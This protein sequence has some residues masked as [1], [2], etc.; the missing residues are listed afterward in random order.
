VQ[1]VH[2]RDYGDFAIGEILWG[3][4][5]IAWGLIELVIITVRKLR[6]D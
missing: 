3:L 1:E 5:E 6:R 2:E 4:V